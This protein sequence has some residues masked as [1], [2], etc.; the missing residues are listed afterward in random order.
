LLRQL[1]IPKLALADQLKAL[2]EAH[3]RKGTR[4]LL[5]EY[6]KL[7]LTAA[8]GFSR[9]FIVIDALDEC[10][11]AEGA[12]DTLL[13][14]IQKMKH[15]ACLLVTSRDIPNIKRVLQDA[16]HLEIRT[17]D[18]DIKGY[19]SERISSSSDLMSHTKK[20]PTLYDAII[21][22]IVGKAQGM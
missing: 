14:E 9:V 11:V 20:D 16:C 10:P 15:R 22:T 19:L 4:P 1:V 8:E 21:T 7:L 13:A 18:E 17:R 5:G 3:D 6:S 12:R 2:R